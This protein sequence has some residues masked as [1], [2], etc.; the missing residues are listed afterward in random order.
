MYVERVPNRGSRPAILLREAWREGKKIRKRTIANLSRWPEARIEM[1][2][3]LLKDEPLVPVGGGDFEVERSLPHGHV[4]AVLG[5]AGKLGLAGLLASRRSPERDRALAMI[6]ARILEPGSK[7]AT[8]RGLDEET[9][10]STLA[11][12]LGIEGATAD[13][14]YAALDWLLARQARIEGKLAKRHLVDGTLLLYDVSSTYFE[15]RH[16]PLAAF[17]HNRDKKKGKLQIVFGLLCTREGCPVAVEVFTGNTSDPETLAPA[18]AKV[19]RRFGLSRVVLVADRGML[20]EARIEAEL[21][22]REGLDWITALR[23]PAIQELVGSGE[24]QLSLFDRQ[25]LAEIASAAFPGERLIACKNPLLAGD[26]ARKREALLQATEAEL[27]KIQAATLRTRRPLRGADKIGVRVGR[28]LGRFKVGKHFRYTITEDGFLYERNAA[29]IRAEAVTDGVYVIRTSVPRDQLS[30]ETTVEAYKALSKVERAFRSYKSGDLEVRPI[31]HR[32]EDR[33]RAHVFLCMLA[34]YVEWHMRQDLAPILFDDHDPAGG[35]AQRRSIVAPAQRS[36]A[37]Q[38]KVRR[39][40]TEDGLPVHSFQ[41]LLLDLR[42]VA[43]H[44][45]SVA[46][47]RFDR[48]TQPTP[49]QAHAFEL[50]GVALHPRRAM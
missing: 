20:T 3:R 29:S 19:S 36:P 48:I 16:C 38:A 18:I 42:T 14:L 28:V 32:A 17:G 22:P 11:E 39:R 49:L 7:L 10:T 31:Y 13:Q 44:R 26:R 25:D 2:R 21:R 46:G 4:A 45:V 30:A 8:A 33:V 50:L 27:G 35:R 24:L 34:Y 15:G 47:A 23:G 41:S 6:C 43:K 1:L 5:A 40:R 12:E 37:A 9:A